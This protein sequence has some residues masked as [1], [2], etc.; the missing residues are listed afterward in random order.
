MQI[1]CGTLRRALKNLVRL[2]P[3]RPTTSTLE[4]VLF[5]PTEEGI[6]RLEP[7]PGQ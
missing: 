3:K 4:H 5:E 6:A 2:V 7:I 1:D